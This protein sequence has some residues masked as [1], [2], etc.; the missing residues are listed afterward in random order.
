MPEMPMGGKIDR[1][2]SLSSFKST[3]SDP[4]GD[5]E[6]GSG[7]DNSSLACP[8]APTRSATFQNKSMRSMRSMRN[9]L[10]TSKTRLL[11]T[12][13]T[14]LFSHGSKSECFTVDEQDDSDLFPTLLSFDTVEI[15]EHDPEVD[16]NPCTSRGRPSRWDGSTPPPN[17]WTFTSMK[18]TGQPDSR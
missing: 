6:Q 17:P 8:A 3:G 9:L 13:L 2:A 15:R 14:S 4:N 12:S 11:G 18:S 7:N 5:A 1:R 10:S 16:A